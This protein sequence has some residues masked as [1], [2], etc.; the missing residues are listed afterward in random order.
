MSYKIIGDSCMDLTEELKRDPHFQ[1]IPLTLQVG[2]YR[3]TDD[4]E[5]DQ[6]DFLEKVKASPECPRTAC[7]SPES[8]KEAFRATDA[9]YIFVVT[10][11]NHLSGSYNS[12]ALAKRLYEEEYGNDNKKIAVIDSLSA[13]AGELNIALFIRDLCEKEFSFEE[14]CRQT[15]EYRDSMK[16][17][18]VIETLDFLKKNGR[19]TGLTAF[20]ASALNIKP[21]MGADRGSIVKLDQARGMN[22]AL[23]RMAEIA[24]KDGGDTSNKRLVIAHCNN[25]K[26]AELVKE[27]MLKRA[28]FREIVITNTAGVATVYAGD[29]GI[30]MTL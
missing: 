22:R 20:I 18:F 1:M 2:D 27:I 25:L 13:S 10:L 28:S 7:P 4:D 19:L 14:I 26:R 17:Y 11:S 16:T 29:G 8:F 3:V 23:D 24:C 30:V 5:F 21:V 15:E 9:E 6:K 12:A